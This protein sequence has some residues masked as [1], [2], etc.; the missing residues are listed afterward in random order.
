MNWYH[1]CYKTK[2]GFKYALVCDIDY[3]IAK[4][5]LAKQAT[6]FMGFIY[7]GP[8]ALLSVDLYLG[9]DNSEPLVQGEMIS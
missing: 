5:R 8:S 9:P 2:N 6:G 3:D 1:I 7:D 4:C